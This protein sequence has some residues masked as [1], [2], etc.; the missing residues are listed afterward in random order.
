MIHRGVPGSRFSSCGDLPR[1]TTQETFL[2]LMRS[3]FEDRG[4]A[5]ALGYLRQIARNQ[6]LMLRRRQSVAVSCFTW[7]MPL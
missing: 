7:G 1:Y 5:A 4:D 3:Q 6:L 2:A